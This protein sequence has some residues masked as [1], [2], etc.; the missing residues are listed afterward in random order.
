M[1]KLISLSLTILTL[2]ATNGS[3]NRRGIPVT[4]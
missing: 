4:K 1:R 3:A 2:I